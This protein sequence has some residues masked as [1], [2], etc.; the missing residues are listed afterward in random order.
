MHT[1]KHKH[2]QADGGHAS[3]CMCLSIS[4]GAKEK[5]MKKKDDIFKGD[6][7]ILWLLIVCVNVPWF[8]DKNLKI[9]F[10]PWASETTFVPIHVIVNNF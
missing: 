4:E 1:H 5:S 3:A 9:V 7:N 2:T 8:Q 10:L 6:T